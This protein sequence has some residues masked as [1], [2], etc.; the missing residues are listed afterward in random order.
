MKVKSSFSSYFRYVIAL[1]ILATVLSGFAVWKRATRDARTE[2]GTSKPKSENRYWSR[3]RAIPAMIDFQKTRI[4]YIDED[5]DDIYFLDEKQVLKY[6]P[7]PYSDE[8][9]DYF[10]RECGHKREDNIESATFWW[11][12]GQLELRGVV[13]GQ[14]PFD[15]T[16]RE[17]LSQSLKVNNYQIENLDSIPKIPL[18]GDWIIR[19]GTTLEQQLAALSRCLKQSVGSAITF[20]KKQVKREVLV[21]NSVHDLKLRSGRN[22]TVSV[23]SDSVSSERMAGGGAG[24]ICKFLNALSKVL[25]IPVINEIGDANDLH[26]SWTWYVSKHEITLDSLENPV[27]KKILANISSQVSIDF[28]EG[29]REIDVWFVKREYSAKGFRGELKGRN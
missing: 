8:R 23:Y 15:R 12:N 10:V 14:P 21:A 6:V 19:K 29:S 18:V 4:D 1:T 5:F 26:I 13:V 28:T 27:I 24:T 11:D 16:L 9:M 25:D 20:E 3:T 2:Y 7:P 22:S 17:V